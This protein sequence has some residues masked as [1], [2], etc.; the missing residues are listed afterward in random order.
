M[1]FTMNTNRN[2]SIAASHIAAL[3]IKV[4]LHFEF[5]AN[6]T[7]AQMCPPV[8]AFQSKWL[9]LKCDDGDSVNIPQDIRSS[10]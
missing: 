8:F 3:N 2:N 4:A 7:C 10:R 6:S 5:R 1:S 9:K